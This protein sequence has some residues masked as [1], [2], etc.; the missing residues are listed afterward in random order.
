MGHER[1]GQLGRFGHCHDRLA[2]GR[3]GRIGRLLAMPPGDPH[4]ILTPWL[5]VPRLGEPL[6]LFRKCRLNADNVFDFA[7]ASHDTSILESSGVERIS[8]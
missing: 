4:Q 5:A 7:F 3:L 8:A 6:V 1:T 2:S